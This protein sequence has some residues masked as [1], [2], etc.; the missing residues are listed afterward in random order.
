MLK[1]L[2]TNHPL[3][4]ILFTVVLVMGLMAYLTLPR[5]QDPEVNFNWVNVNTV[6]PGA[7]AEDVEELITGPLED[8]VR[9]VQDV[10]WIVSTSRESSSN[11]LVRFYELSSRNF[12]KRVNDLRRELQNK[13]NDELPEE[14]EDPL[15]L[16]LTTSNGFPSALIIV[17]GQADDEKL[18]STAKRISDD[19]V[20]LG[21]VD[22]VLAIGLHD[23]ELQVEFLPR[24]L[25]ARGL[26][27]TDIADSL[28]LAFRDVFAGKAPVES[29]EWLV[30]INGS[31][32]NPQDLANF[33][34]ATPDRPGQMTA[35]EQ[36][37]EI[38]R[39][40]QEATQLVSF[41][42]LPGVGLS[43]TKVAGTNTL[44]LVDRL[45]AYVAQQNRLLDGSGL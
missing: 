43:V 37:A 9:N 40:R 39:G 33:Q 2:L 3:V 12:D 22:K 29:G 36:V 26:K 31:S 17:T 6:L 18:R 44:E 34:L 28:R 11:I 45:N 32:A 8:A 14:A 21:G 15:I 20:R 4:N 38:R 42:G 30:R 25:A 1:R 10:R 5:E 23:P 7:S 19:L 16:E 27:A 41:N 13:F 24:E 35:L